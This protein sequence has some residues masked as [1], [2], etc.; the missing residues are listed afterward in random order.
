MELV[1]RSR[2][3]ET[4]DL[5]DATT[6]IIEPYNETASTTTYSMRTDGDYLPL[7]IERSNLTINVTLSDDA[8]TVMSMKNT[9]TN[10]SVKFSTRPAASN[11]N[12]LL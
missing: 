9:R 2:L 4:T 12:T 6:E 5:G 10:L 11:P 3:F 8:Y 7:K 1:G